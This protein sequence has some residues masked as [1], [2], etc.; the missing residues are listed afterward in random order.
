MNVLDSLTEKNI[1]SLS[2]EE[3][4]GLLKQ[5]RDEIDLID[6]SIVEL[7][8][9]RADKYKKLSSLKQQLNN[10]SPLREKEIIERIAGSGKSNLN[11]KDLVQIF[12]RIIDVSRAIQKKNRNKN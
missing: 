6:D 8:D 3:M 9:Y 4:R 5:I 12:E 10:Y 11:S 2:Q 1:E 7:L